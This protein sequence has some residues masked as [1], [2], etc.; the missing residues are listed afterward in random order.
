MSVMLGAV[1]KVARETIRKVKAVTNGGVEREAHDLARRVPP[2][3]LQID[4]GEGY[5]RFA[6][7]EIGLDREVSRLASLS[8]T[9]KPAAERGG[10]S[11]AGDKDYIRYLLLPADLLDVPEV[12]DIVLHPELFGSVTKYLGQVPWLVTVKV[13]WTLRNQTAVKSQLYHYDHRDTRQAKIFINLNEVGED[14]GPLHFLP[15]SASRKVDRRIGYSQGDYTDEQVYD[16]VSR[17]DVIKTVGPPG[18]GYIVDTARCLHYGSRGNLEDRLVLAICYSRVNC[19]DAGSGCSVL[20]PVRDRL[21]RERYAHD[22]AIS[23]SLRP[24]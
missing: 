20:D 23:F 22:A 9:W 7:E 8:E 15:A 6:A 1:H 24:H 3:R 19:V 4:D 21:V 11:K 2:A 18:A 10:M 14:A 5:A 16:S 12:M 17:D 13:W